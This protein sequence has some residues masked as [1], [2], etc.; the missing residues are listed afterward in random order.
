M[1]VVGVLFLALAYVA[2]YYWAE[3]LWFDELGFLS[4]F[5]GRSRTQL[6]L[7]TSTLFTSL[8]FTFFNFNVAKRLQF[9]RNCLIPN[10][11]NLSVGLGLNQL[12]PVLFVIGTLICAGLF[13]HIQLPRA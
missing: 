13:H 12:L 5:L 10:Q 3:G 4:E 11:A 8:A 9:N 7:G 1:V 6:I 2:T